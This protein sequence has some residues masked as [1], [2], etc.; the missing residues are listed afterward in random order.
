[1]AQKTIVLD[2][3][4][5]IH[6]YTGW[7]GG[8]LNKPIKGAKEAIKQFETDGFDVKIFSTRPADVIENWLVDNN[9]PLI[10]VCKDK[11][12][13]FVMVDDRSYRFD[14]E[15]NSQ[16]IED[17]ESFTPYWESTKK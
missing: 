14:G 3:D 2:F 9:F 7:N 8:K 15:W 1:M 13:C 4:A 12:K 10:P 11:P 16:V 6:Q 17:I 5:V